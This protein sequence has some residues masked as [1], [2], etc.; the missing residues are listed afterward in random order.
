MPTR[1]RSTGTLIALAASK[2]TVS[3]IVMRPA[4]GVSSPAIA[5]IVVVLPQPE[6]PSSTSILPASTCRSRSA[7]T[8]TSPNDFSSP[9]TSMLTPE[10]PRR[11]PR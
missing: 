4:E 1:R 5:R 6:G 2:T 3:P 8:R 9:A 11:R 7:M 10:P